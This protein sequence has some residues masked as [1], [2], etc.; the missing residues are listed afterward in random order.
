MLAA[1]SVCSLAASQ[2]RSSAQDS[3]PSNSFKLAVD[4]VGLTFHAADAR[5]LPVNDLR[6][7]ELSLSDAG[8][9]PRRIVSFFALQDAPIRA[10]LLLDT[11]QSMAANL[12][13][14]KAVSAHFA[15]RVL[16]QS[17]DQGFVL[18]FGYISSLEQPWT[19]NPAALS[20]AAS[21]TVI[22]H[23]NPLGGTALYDAVFR[24][25]FHEFG[26]VDSAS[27][28]N[29][30]LLFSD[31]EDNSSH[32]SLAEVVNICQRSN[33]AVYAFRADPGLGMF[34]MGSRDLR[35][36]AEQTGGRVFPLDE[37]EANV[38]SDLRAIEANLRNQY[39]LIYNP[40][41]LPHDG[42]FH[43]IDLKTPQR[44]ANIT[45]RSGYY[46]QPR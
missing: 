41:V 30:I 7:D 15:Q 25:C 10:G 35:E 40:P 19:S 13:A 43:R 11:S 37:S 42:A 12:H 26:K 34:A 38:D 8:L 1:F 31:G 23:D 29:F 36:L 18:T 3:V 39:R 46:D 20:D 24:A 32:T 21:H 44:V 6:L 2:V 14:V 4:E 5:G 28:G 16:R 33:T 22:G 17:T 9:P 45:I 27:S